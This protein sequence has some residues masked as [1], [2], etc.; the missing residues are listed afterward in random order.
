MHPA[1]SWTAL[2]Q[3]VAA[4]L[5]LPSRFASARSPVFYFSSYTPYLFSGGRRS[6]GC[7]RDV[8]VVPTRGP[9]LLPHSLPLWPCRPPLVPC[10]CLRVPSLCPRVPSRLPL[11][12]N[13]LILI[14]IQC[15][16]PTFDTCV[17]RHVISLCCVEG[18][19]CVYLLIY[20]IAT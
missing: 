4:L 17:M 8:L 3:V 6:S 2:G 10:L 13:I 15:T 5:S 20:S 12:P 16:Q 7:H 1:S 18:S 14:S 11:V 19:G 9:L